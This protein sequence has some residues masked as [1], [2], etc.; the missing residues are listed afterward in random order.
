MKIDF[1]PNFRRAYKKRILNNQKL[2]EKVKERVKIFQENP[3]NPLLRDHALAG[4]KFKYRSFSITGDIRIIYEQQDNK[5]VFHD[6]GTHNQV[7]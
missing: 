4:S 6:I 2:V 5:I 7:Y 3:Q 1:H